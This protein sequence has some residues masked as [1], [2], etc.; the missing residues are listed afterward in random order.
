MIPLQVHTE[1]HL[2]IGARKNIYDVIL[3]GKF[4]QNHTTTN[5]YLWFFEGYSSQNLGRTI[6]SLSVKL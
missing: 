5:F 3:K 4:R 2:K 6:E 1:F